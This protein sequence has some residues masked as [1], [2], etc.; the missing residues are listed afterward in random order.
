[1]TEDEKLF[2]QAFRFAGGLFYVENENIPELQ[3]LVKEIKKGYD[4]LH[5]YLK[6]SLPRLPKIHFDIIFNMRL[7]ACA[8]KLD[9]QYFVGINLGTY[10]ILEDMF[11]KLMASKNVLPDIGDISLETPEKK[12]LSIITKDTGISF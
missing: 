8:T 12:I 5:Y 1:M 3:D 10:L 11:D 4:G 6:H 2:D 9:N 7:N